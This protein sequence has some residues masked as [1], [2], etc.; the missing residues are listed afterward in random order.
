MVV[1]M[2]S[3]SKIAVIISGHLRTFFACWPTWIK[4]ANDNNFI[5]DYYVHTYDSFFGD[6]SLVECG[7]LKHTQACDL[8]VN[9]ALKQ[10]NPV[11]HVISSHED[12]EKIILEDCKVLQSQRIYN[13]K[14]EHAKFQLLQAK[15]I[16]LAYNL[17]EKTK[18]HDYDYV[19]RLRA[20]FFWR[21]SIRMPHPKDDQIITMHR[22]KPSPK[23]VACDIFGFMTPNVAKKY[24]NIYDTLI[25][26]AKTDK[27]SRYN[28]EVHL[29]MLLSE[30]NITNVELDHCAA[31]LRGYDD[32]ISDI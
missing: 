32:K 27:M 6:Q 28:L 8:S 22:G 15:K 17:F 21:E 10:I 16:Q 9:E 31:L 29:G 19:V 13:T 7:V 4:V 3:S 30:N 5:C 20:D 23:N 24:F 14:R 12:I 11:S 18:I 2:T 25:E 26:R 1:D